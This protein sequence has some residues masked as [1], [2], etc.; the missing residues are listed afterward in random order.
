MKRIKKKQ[1]IK[2]Q[3][4]TNN[5]Y[6][7]AWWRG[8]RWGRAL[9]PCSRWRWRARG[10]SSGAAGTRPPCRRWS[11]Q[12]APAATTWATIGRRSH[13]IKH[14]E[15]SHSHKHSQRLNSCKHSQRSKSHNILKGQIVANKVYSS[16]VKMP[17]NH[18]YSQKLLK[19]YLI[20]NKVT[21]SKAT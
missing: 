7:P 17:H 3:I 5:F 4:I 9:R 10:G 12:S 13:S 19:I 8:C 20:A 18:I 11:S 21:W 14:S 6:W 15:R 1:V 2:G 16:L